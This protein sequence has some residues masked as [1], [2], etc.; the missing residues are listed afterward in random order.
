MITAKGVDEKIYLSID[1]DTTYRDKGFYKCRDCDRPVFLKRSNFRTNHFSH[2]PF[3]RECKQ[4]EKDTE[5]H[6]AMKVD[7]YN[8]FK[9]FYWICKIDV[10]TPI[11]YGDSFIKPD[12]FIKAK[13]GDQIAIE[14]QITKITWSEVIEKIKKY[15]SMNI[16]TLFIFDKYNY[17]KDFFSVN[18][19]PYEM[20]INTLLTD[21]IQTRR[22]YLYNANK[23]NKKKYGPII[24]FEQIGVNIANMKDNKFY[25][26]G[27]YFNKEDFRN[28]KIRNVGGCKI[29][30]GTEKPNFGKIVKKVEEHGCHFDPEWVIYDNI[31]NDANRSTSVDKYKRL[32]E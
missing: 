18:T 32:K 6:T 20:S 27:T 4:W 1:K 25:F 14:C 5:E 11:P 9:N 22:F 24:S 3:D 7:I 31:E 2:F 21:N 29:V 12:I 28:Y 10:E 23:K 8:Y 26:S 17:I 13:N 19:T 16:G 30:S 15:S